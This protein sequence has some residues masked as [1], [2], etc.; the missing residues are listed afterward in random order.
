MKIAVVLC[1]SE[2]T[3]Q[4]DFLAF[5]TGN[6]RQVILPHKMIK[7]LICCFSPSF[8]FYFDCLRASYFTVRSIDTIKTFLPIFISFKGVDR[9]IRWI[10]APGYLIQLCADMCV[11][12]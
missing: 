4:N 9:S 10:Q 3:M 5:M 11:F 6:S 2:L 12:V 8:L 1:Y 7:I